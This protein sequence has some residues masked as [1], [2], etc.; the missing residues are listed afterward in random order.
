M[1]RNQFDS[2]YSRVVNSYKLPVQGADPSYNALPR[3]ACG[4]CCQS[5]RRSGL[6]LDE[7]KT[8]L[9]E[10]QLAEAWEYVMLIN[11]TDIFLGQ[12]NGINKQRNAQMSDQLPQTFIAHNDVL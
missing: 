2:R 6:A 1:S 10:S 4:L 12:R 3:T 5:L 7:T 11:E 9:Q 8:K